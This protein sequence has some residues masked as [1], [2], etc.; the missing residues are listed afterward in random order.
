MLRRRRR[1]EA[2]TNG[3]ASQTMD[4]GVFGG[5]VSNAAATVALCALR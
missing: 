5:P 3:T 4:L 1:S 2:R